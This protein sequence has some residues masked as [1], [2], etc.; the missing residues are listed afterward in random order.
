MVIHMR[1]IKGAQMIEPSVFS[2]KEE[3]EL[4]GLRKELT[5]IKKL[6][7]SRLVFIA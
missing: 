7:C 1:K 5:F 6:L 4:G 3:L 2:F